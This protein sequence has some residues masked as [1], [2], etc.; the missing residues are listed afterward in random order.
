MPPASAPR[1]QFETET[2]EAQPSN[3]DYR[4][5]AAGGVRD[6][7]LIKPEHLGDVEGIEVRPAREPN[8]EGLVSLDQPLVIIGD[9]A[10]ERLSQLLGREVEIGERAIG[11]LATYGQANLG[12]NVYG[13]LTADGV[14]EVNDHSQ[15]NLDG[16]SIILRGMSAQG[17]VRSSRLAKIDQVYSWKEGQQLEGFEAFYE[18]LRALMED[19][20]QSL[21]LNSEKLL[22]RLK[23]G[24]GYIQLVPGKGDNPP[25]YLRIGSEGIHL[26]SPSDAGV[27]EMAAIE[28][29]TGLNVSVTR[30][31]MHNL[32][33][34][35][36]YAVIGKGLIVARGRYTNHLGSTFY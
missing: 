12:S 8:K 25:F 35:M 33:D 29:A 24:A 20:G 18:G 15:T 34:D 1:P 2:G 19:V 16:S 17:S 10:R 21:D 13:R 28:E 23:K 7:I 36:G 11:E 9:A 30:Q 27:G 4:A 3:L 26:V 14:L 6:L 22:E 5:P 31:R 32:L